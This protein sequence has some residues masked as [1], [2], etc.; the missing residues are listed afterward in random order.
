MTSDI[1]L[2]IICHVVGPGSQICQETCVSL[3]AGNRNVSPI[4]QVSSAAPVV[5]DRLQIVDLTHN[6]VSSDCFENT[7][8]SDFIKLILT[9]YLADF[10]FILINSNFY[11]HVLK[12]RRYSHRLSIEYPHMKSS[13]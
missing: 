8:T 9:V 10:Y 5:L 3:T 12:M 2:L 7:N 1:V 6:Y 13:G 4:R 11:L